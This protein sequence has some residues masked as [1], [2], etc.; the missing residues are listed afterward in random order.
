[1]LRAL[2][3]DDEAPAR[4]EL[5]YILGKLDGV[6]IVGEAANAQEALELIKNVGHDVVFLDI[7]MPGLNGLEVAKAIRQLKKPPAI[8]FVTAYGEHAVK[9]FELEAIDYVIKPFEKKRL[10]QAVNK[11]RRRYPKVREVR[12]KA[13]EREKFLE[14]IV[15]EKSGKKI[16]LAPKEIFFF[17]ARDDYAI[18]YTFDNRYLL[19]STLKKLEERLRNYHFFRVHRKYIVNLEKVGEIISLSRGTFLLRMKDKTQSEI[20][21]SRRRSRQFREALGF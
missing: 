18:L 15:V 2:I 21:V 3:V 4:A 6:K 20:L 11:V 14:R 19:S 5:R 12:K 9:A 7:E 1:M 10:A 8:V 16:P 17:E 13:E